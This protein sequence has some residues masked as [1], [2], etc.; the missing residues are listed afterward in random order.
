MHRKLFVLGGG[1]AA[2]L[3]IMAAMAATTA[4]DR[5]LP[6]A[7]LNNVAGSSRS[8]VAWS[9]GNTWMTGDDFTVGAP[10][11]TWIVTGIKT[12]QVG[13]VP[14]SSAQFGDRYADVSLYGG[15]ANPGGV[16]LITS[17]TLSAGSSVNSNANITHTKVNYVD[18]SQPNYEGT[19]GTQIQLWETTFTGLTWL[20][21]GG[22]K[23]NFAVDGTVRST[24]SSAYFFNHASNAA[25]SGSPQQG[26]DG[27]FLGWDKSDMSAAPFACDS[28]NTTSCGGWDKS[29]DINVVV[30]A[31][32]AVTEAK[33]CKD[34][35]WTTL[36][37]LDGSSF[38]NQ[39]DCVSY[40]QNGR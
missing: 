27:Y 36:V 13:M 34:S 8:N 33:A 17:G 37:R 1:A 38:K 12:W 30:T 28:G 26:S 14:N 35:G 31:V 15:L 9:F 40:A 2:L 32:L 10:G 29:S 18:P 22:T 5:G 25:L 6:T 7:H 20:V 4:T 23:Y 19:T 16:S 21:E 11:E 24:V 3:I 39:G